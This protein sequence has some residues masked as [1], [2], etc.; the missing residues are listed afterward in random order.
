MPSSSQP[1]QITTVRT[2]SVSAK[3]T[4]NR[5]YE[6]ISESIINADQKPEEITRGFAV[7]ATRDFKPSPVAQMIESLPEVMRMIQSVAEADDEGD[8]EDARGMEFMLD[9]V[10]KDPNPEHHIPMISIT[11]SPS[12]S[13]VFLADRQ[14]MLRTPD[15]LTG[16][17]T[18]V[19]KAARIIPEDQE[20]DLL[21]IPNVLPS[22]IARSTMR[23]DMV[24]LFADWPDELGPSLDSD[25]LTIKGPA[26]VVDV[27]AA[28]V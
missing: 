15:E 4:F 25:A 20:L 14:Y 18:V 21:T 5:L 13:V 26:I 2:M 10:L 6:K 12:Y 7:E 22:R 9:I 11:A 8:D 28:F 24:E 17:M 23:D 16:E 1:G 3:H 27:L 19:G